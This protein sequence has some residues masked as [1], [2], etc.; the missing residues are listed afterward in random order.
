MH[1]SI[2]ER[3]SGHC[4]VRTTLTSSIH[5][6]AMATSC[7]DERRKGPGS[8]LAF[9]SALDRR[10]SDNRPAAT[11]QGHKEQH[12]RDDEQQVDE[13]ADR[14]GAH[15]SEQPRD[16]QNHD[17]CVQ[18][19]SSMEPAETPAISSVLA[20]DLLANVL[21][22]L[23]D[24]ALRPTKRR[25][26]IARDLVD[27]SL[28]TQ[29][30]VVGEISGCLLHLALDRF[31]LAFELVLVHFSPS[32]WSRR[33]SGAMGYDYHSQSRPTKVALAPVPLDSRM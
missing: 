14:V 26:S 11:Q 19:G 29:L 4:G 5:A 12:N 21:Y 7:A 22:R 8:L 3:P 13:R 16:Q 1:A 24:L 30:L 33:T 9:P 10:C 20:L 28:I 15:Q 31:S 32:A 2:T 23:T 27:N 18:H 17:K 25:L 6:S